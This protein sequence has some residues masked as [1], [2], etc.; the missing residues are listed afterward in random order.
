MSQ[1]ETYVSYATLIEQR[2]ALYNKRQ[3][4]EY[5]TENLAKYINKIYDDL[6]SYKQEE[7]CEEEDGY[8]CYFKHDVS[9]LK[10]EKLQEIFY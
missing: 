10:W 7:E 9:D 1:I 4:P 6:S 5:V 8:F 3:Y 2:Q